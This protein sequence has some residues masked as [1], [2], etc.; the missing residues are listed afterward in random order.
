MSSVFKFTFVLGVNG[1]FVPLGY[2]HSRTTSFSN[3]IFLGH[4]DPVFS[5]PDPE[6]C[7]QF[8]KFFLQMFD[9]IMILE[10]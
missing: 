9:S 1:F 3:P 2:D 4:P 8:P 6:K 7:D 5:P 10:T